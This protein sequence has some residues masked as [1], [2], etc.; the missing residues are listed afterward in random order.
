ME[1]GEGCASQ[2]GL[3][4]VPSENV[5]NFTFESVHSGAFGRLQPPQN[6]NE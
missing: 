6:I 3:G 1:S 4:A 2:W 5:W